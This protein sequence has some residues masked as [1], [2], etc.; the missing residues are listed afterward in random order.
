M[1]ANRFATMLH[2]NTHKLI[3]VL[4]YALLEWVLII[5]LLFNSLFSYLINKFADYFG[6]TK[7]C[8]WCSR[9]DHILEP[10]KG[11]KSYTDLVCESH[12]ME[13]SQLGYCSN[14]QKVAES[15]KM[16]ENCL[17]SRP[18]YT[19]KTTGITRRMAFISWMGDNNHE[20]D[21]NI[22]ECSCCN[23]NLSS[24]NH[25]PNLLFKSSWGSLEYNQKGDLI[26]EAVDHD[27]NN[28]SEYQGPNKPVEL[29]NH[30]K[31]IGCEIEMDDEEHDDHIRVADKNQ[32]PCNFH[33]FS[34]RETREEDCLSS[35]SM[36][37]CY[38]KEAMEDNKSSSLDMARQ[39]SN[40]TEFA[41]QFSD[42]STT[43]CCCSEE[44]DLVDAID[45]SSKDLRICGLNHR[46]IPIELIDFSTRADQGF[47]SI[48]EEDLKEHCNVDEILC[49][50]HSKL[51]VPGE[52]CLLM[53]NENAEKMS[54]GEFE[55]EMGEAAAD[56][57]SM[58]HA[59][60]RKQELVEKESGHVLTSQEVRTFKI[61]VKEAA[62]QEQNHPP[63]RN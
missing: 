46:L 45:L 59:E 38:E 60:E 35:A 24:K 8:L 20:N 22:F 29:P 39:D 47:C 50:H 58:G 40:G 21:K 17:A 16:C 61:N 15:Q 10:G 19:G 53:I 25:R 51:E 54:Y 43:Q 3:L 11:T 26:L 44:D 12:A 56:E 48:E 27:N 57:S 55:S 13:I 49:C 4:V 1:A 18:N 62:V 32:L 2:R 6:L 31:N 9:V 52:P 7:P 30:S 5:L 36:F 14:H 34:L 41:H 33:S 63:G 28:G 37:I 42:G 23:E